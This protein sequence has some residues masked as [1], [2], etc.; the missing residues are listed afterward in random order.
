LELDTIDN[1]ADNRKVL[2]YIEQSDSFNPF[3]SL[4]SYNNVTERYQE[5]DQDKLLGF[6]FKVNTNS[7]VIWLYQHA[8]QVRLVKRSKNLYAMLN[9]TT[10]V[11]LDRDV[12]K[13][14][15]R[16]DIIIIGNKIITGN[17]ELLQKEF[18][19]QKYVRSEAQKVISAIATL[20]I[21]SDTAKILQFESKDKLTN[22]KKLLKVKNSAVLKIPKEMLIPKIKA[23]PRYKDKFKF[24]N[25]QIVI[26]TLK[27][28][29]ELLKMMDDDILRSD[30]TGQEYNSTAKQILDPIPV[31]EQ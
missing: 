19:F 30:L 21:V 20:G 27:D 15:S 12:L 14:D 28:V 17:L 16:I 13:F 18:G 1:I 22:A 10:Y 11:P 5:Q 4:Q 31:P 2:Y 8:Y 29:T 26:A 9:G 7:N 23:H 6:A 3:L 25:E 24:E